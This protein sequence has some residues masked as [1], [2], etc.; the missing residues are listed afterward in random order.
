[1]FLCC[2]AAPP[3]PLLLL[4]PLPPPALRLIDS[5]GLLLLPV[6]L[7]I[8]QS[9][10]T[11]SETSSRSL[12]SSGYSA[13]RLPAALAPAQALAQQLNFIRI[14]SQPPQ[15]AGAAPGGD[16]AAGALLLRAAT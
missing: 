10:C 2:S 13:P 5:A 6:L 7:R 11:A 16:G 14:S 4:R 9:L 8:M 12:V 3:P 15:R 1:M